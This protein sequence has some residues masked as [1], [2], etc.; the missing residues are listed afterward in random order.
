MLL[1]YVMCSF[2]TPEYE[3]FLYSELRLRNC[4]S[5][6]QNFAQMYDIGKKKF[7]IVR[8]MFNMYSKFSRIVHPK[9]LNKIAKCTTYSL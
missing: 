6:Q 3:D 9:Q 1:Q 7:Y 2:M 4:Q 8:Q 5:V